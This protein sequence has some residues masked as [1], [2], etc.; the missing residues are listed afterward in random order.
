MVNETIVPEKK[1]TVAVKEQSTA[2]KPEKQVIKPDKTTEKSGEYNVEVVRDFYGKVDPF[3]L[4]KKDP[5]YAYRFLRDDTK[6][7]GKNISIKTGNLL[8]DKGGWQL[9]PKAHLV[10]L[11]IK[12]SELSPDN[13]LR[14][15]DTVLAFMPKKLFD[16][17]QAHKVKEAKERMDAV[18]RM[19]NQGDPTQGGTSVHPT[20]RGL[21]T[22]KQLGMK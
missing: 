7:G 9:C 6:A 12:E 20:M 14:R 13:L 11:G 17:K 5:N 16:E 2:I 8:F 18:K 1:E 15:G 10:R 4:T 3:Y 21:Q 22:G 19:V